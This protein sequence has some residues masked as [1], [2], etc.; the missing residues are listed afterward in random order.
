MPPW[1]S[2]HVHSFDRPAPRTGTTMPLPDEGS[3]RIRRRS[4]APTS[5]LHAK[6]N[7]N[8]IENCDDDE[9]DS[10][11]AELKTPEVAPRRTGKR[12][13]LQGDA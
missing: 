1:L 11:W 4:S 8:K 13:R 5:P 3:P 2:C 7:I 9:K 10:E 12:R 6:P